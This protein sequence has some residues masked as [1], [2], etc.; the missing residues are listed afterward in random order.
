MVSTFLLTS[1]TGTDILLGCPH[2]SLRPILFL[3]PPLGD[4]EEVV[5][6][7]SHSDSVPLRLS[8]HR[9]RG[10]HII[11]YLG[12]G[13]DKLHRRTL[14][15]LRTGLKSGSGVSTYRILICVELT[16]DLVAAHLSAT[17]SA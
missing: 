14:S 10:T 2:R 6:C 3:L 17:F 8:F 13:P 9:C 15:P 7:S 4:L 16:P 11:Q 1:W 5:C 12:V